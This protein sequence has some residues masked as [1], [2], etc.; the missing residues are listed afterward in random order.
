[1][2]RNTTRILSFFLSFFFH[3]GGIFQSDKLT[4]LSS[5][6]PTNS[7]SARPPDRLRES[8]KIRKNTEKQ[9]CYA[10][11]PAPSFDVRL[12]LCCAGQE[13]WRTAVRVLLSESED[14]SVRLSAWALS[15]FE[16]SS[17]SLLSESCMSRF[18]SSRLSL[19]RGWAPA[20]APASASCY[21]LVCVG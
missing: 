7:K 1:M 10:T 19:N 15:C 11:F 6:H 3:C 12:T 14:T 9:L 16:D 18:V 17:V 21:R 8:E 2:S 5:S 4:V 20:P 13:T